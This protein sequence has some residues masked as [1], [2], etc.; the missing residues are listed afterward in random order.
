[1]KRTNIIRGKMELCKIDDLEFIF[2]KILYESEIW[3]S[4]YELNEE[5]SNL[6]ELESKRQIKKCI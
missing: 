2:K 5:I 4:V 6:T 3:V 1:M